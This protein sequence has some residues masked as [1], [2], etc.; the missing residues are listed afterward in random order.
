MP[1]A[2][3]VTVIEEGVAVVIWEQPDMPN[4]AIINYEIR[5]TGQGNQTTVLTDADVLHYSFT[6]IPLKNNGTIIIE[7][8]HR[9]YI[10]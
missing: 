4:G 6:N 3:K 1:S 10:F 9:L 2:P 8:R 7:V 5:F